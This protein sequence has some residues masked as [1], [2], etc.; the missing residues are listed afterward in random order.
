MHILLRPVRAVLGACVFTASVHGTVPS[1]VPVSARRMG[2]QKRGQLKGI[3]QIVRPASVLRRRARASGC[4]GG[5]AL[6]ADLNLP[7][8]PGQVGPD[9]L[10]KFD[11]HA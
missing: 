2:Y 4:A 3:A 6:I 5:N 8:L 7:K 10:E 11:V 9:V 1:A